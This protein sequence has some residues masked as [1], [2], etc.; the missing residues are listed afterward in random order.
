MPRNPSEIRRCIGRIFSPVTTFE[1]VLLRRPKN[2]SA[3]TREDE[4]LGGANGNVADFG[5]RS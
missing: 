5:F 1:I 3:G 4:R 2:L